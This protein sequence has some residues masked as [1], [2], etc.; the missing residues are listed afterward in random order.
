MDTFLEKRPWYIRYRYYLVIGILLSVILIWLGSVAFGPRR[1]RVNSGEVQVAEVRKD[2]FMEYVDVEGSVQ[3]ILT[4]LVNAR[5]SGTVK[6][7]VAEEGSLLRKGDTILVLD[8]PVLLREIEDQ[9]DEWEQHFFGYRQ[10][11]IEMEQKTLVLRQQALDAAYELEKIRKNFALEQEEF[12]MGIRSKAQ[13]DVSADEYRY[14]SESTRLKMESLRS[15]SALTV[16]NRELLR[17]ERERARKKLERAEL[18]SR[19]LVVHAPADG[20]LSF[21]KVIPG[22]QVT[23]GEDLAEVKVMS[24]FKIHTLLNEYYIDRMTTGLPATI[25]HNGKHYPL[26]VSKVVPEVKE[27]NFEVDMLF[28]DSLPESARL[29]KSYRVQIEL[30]QPEQVLVIPRG[31]FYQYTGGHWIFR[32]DETK[33]YAV[34]V[35]IV[36]GRQNPQQYEIVSGL[37]PGDRI[38]TAGYANFSDAEAVVVGN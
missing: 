30:G 9:R 20:Q 27:R 22:Q 14:K 35:P 7:I 6:R 17:K 11:E 38:I 15:D 21:V 26:R 36:I 5:E 4:L 34:R 10:A 28:V 29:G 3:P 37:Q 2:D 25:T 12:N 32:L 33:G 13:L 19:D 18:R 24:Q 31:D 23:V 1:L 16:V 8:N